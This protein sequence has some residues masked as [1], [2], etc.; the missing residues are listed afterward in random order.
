MG[1][2]KEKRIFKLTFEDP[3]LAG[4]EVRVRSVSMLR[5]FELKRLASTNSPGV[6]EGFVEN[7]IDWNLE[8][9][10]KDGTAPV[11]VTVDDLMR[12]QEEHFVAAMVLAWFG[13]I[14]GVPAPL[15]H[16]S[17]D[18]EPSPELSTLSMETLS[19]PL[20]N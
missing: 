14:A 9:K 10:T 16:G 5:F 12:T 11:P 2:I 20:M 4:L 3:E 1:F 6:I 13:G 15:D 19:E 8:E 7:V 18:G 17:S